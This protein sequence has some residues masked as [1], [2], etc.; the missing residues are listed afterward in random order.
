MC[1]LRLRREMEYQRGCCVEDLQPYMLSRNKLAVNLISRNYNKATVM[2]LISTCNFFLIIA[3]L[4]M[5]HKVHSDFTNEMEFSLA[6]YV[7]SCILFK[8]MQFFCKFQ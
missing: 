4:P 7:L 5:S 1:N 3:K 2:F 6:V 8:S